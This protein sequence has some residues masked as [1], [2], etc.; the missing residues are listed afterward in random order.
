VAGYRKD[1]GNDRQDCREDPSGLPN[2]RSKT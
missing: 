2:D 1:H